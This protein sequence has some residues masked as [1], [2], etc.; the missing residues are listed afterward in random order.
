MPR[1]IDL[2]TEKLIEYDVIID[3]DPL[4][5]NLL[6][7]NPVIREVCYAGR[8]LC[9][10]LKAINCPDYIIGTIMCCAG[11]A[12]FGCEDTWEVHRIMLDQFIDGSLQVGDNFEE[13][14]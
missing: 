7:N 8:W 11:V 2:T 14:N 12:S 4:L 5:D 3:N 6:A 10:K 1:P 13:K 9:D